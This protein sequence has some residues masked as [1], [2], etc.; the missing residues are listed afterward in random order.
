[1]KKFMKWSAAAAAALGL[2]VFGGMA[3]VNA[4]AVNAEQ[5]KAIAFEHAGVA[6]SD[7]DSVR[8]KEDW[9]WGRTVYEIEFYA[10]TTE[11]DYDIAKD[12]GEILQADYEVHG[13]YRGGRGQSGSYALSY[14]DA[15]NKVLARVPGATEQNLRMKR[16]HDHGRATYEGE[17]RYNGYEYDFELDAETGEFLEW[18]SERDWF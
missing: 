4:A 2:S 8:V 16:D 3:V 9:D 14:G 1:M 6:A 12:S 10:G 5:A 17:L 15:V 7:V 13:G 18:N 11:Y